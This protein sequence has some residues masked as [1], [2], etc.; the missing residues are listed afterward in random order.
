MSRLHPVCTAE[1]NHPPHRDTGRLVQAPGTADRGEMEAMFAALYEGEPIEY[2]GLQGDS[3][4]RVHTWRVGAQPWNPPPRASESTEGKQA[5]NSSAIYRSQLWTGDGPPGSPDFSRL[6]EPPPAHFPAPLVTSDL[7][8]QLSQPGPVT[9]L[10]ARAAA[11]GWDTMITYAKGWTP[12]ATHGT[13]SKQAK[14]S[15]AVR[16]RRG[17]FRA[18]AVR[19]GGTWASM[20]TWSDTDRFTHHRTLAAFE[21]AIQ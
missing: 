7:P 18:V 19:M 17:P 13:P 9:D 8:V 5:K 3:E 2:L 1:C 16:L 15:W 4:H 14:E 11:L 10:E 20:W 21:E 6:V 12:H